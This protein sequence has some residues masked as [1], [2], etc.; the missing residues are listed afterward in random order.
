MY[1]FGS[2]NSS[3]NP[4][5]KDGLTEEREKEKE[6]NILVVLSCSR[7]IP[8]RMTDT[9]FMVMVLALTGCV[10]PSASHYL[11]MDPRFPAYLP[12]S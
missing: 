4:T 2:A 6:R 9:G 10:S 5:Y 1:L 3:Q 8:V 11:S 12:L 7:K